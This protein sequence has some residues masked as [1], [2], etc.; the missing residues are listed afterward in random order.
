MV[1]LS[2]LLGQEK[3][4]KF[5]AVE[6]TGITADS[7]KV[8][9][10]YLFV[11][12]K[13]SNVDGARF[14]PA[15]IENGAA[16]ILAGRDAGSWDDSV[17]IIGADHPH[18]CLARIAAR[19]YH[20]QPQNVVAVTGTNGKSSVCH[21]L[22]QLWQRAG[23]A[24]ASFG[25]LGIDTSEGHRSLGLTTPD[26]VTLHR[27]IARLADS[28]ITDLA[29]EASSHGLD[30][31]RL[32]GVKLAAG[33]FTNLSQ[34]H[35]DYHGTMEAYLQAKLRLF[36]DLLASGSPAVVFA[37][38]GGDIWTDAIAEIAADRDLKLISYGAKG[39]KFTITAADLSGQTLRITSDDTET[40]LGDWQADVT[41]P[42]IGSFQA[43]N[44]ICALTLFLA[45]GGD[46][47]IGLGALPQLQGVDGRMQDAGTLP[48]GARVF[49]DYSHT[50]GGLTAALKS[51]RPHTDGRITTVFGCGGDRDPAKRPLMGQAATEL[52]DRVIVTDDNP[53]SEDPALI[54][55][56]A[57]TG[58]PGAT[59]IGDRAQ[60]IRDAIKHLGDGDVALIAGKGHE[61]G[62]IVGDEVLPFSDLAISREIILELGGVPS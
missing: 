41:L 15:A 24:A 26:P 12:L 47:T 13:G 17:A 61:T 31:H 60:A 38:P 39:I 50:S 45:R 6:I 53:R 14:I 25:T 23:R 8:Q 28:N 37:A 9:D 16:A 30:Q 18:H 51:L 48:N 44:A 58:A 27:E 36:S 57:L 56:A 21:F 1:R 46:L 42:F 7:R 22:R 55:A 62:Q 3:A 54:R 29:M 43:E 5:G 40:G 32:D 35:F 49:I 20:R 19:F 10:G 59:E 2:D 11:A 4:G 33:A 52:S 34:D